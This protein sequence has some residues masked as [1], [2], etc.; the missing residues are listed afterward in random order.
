VQLS[1]SNIGDALDI[2]SNNGLEATSANRS[3]RSYDGGYV[4]SCSQAAWSNK[5]PCVLPRH[6]LVRF[7]SGGE[8]KAE[9]AMTVDFHVD[10][11]SSPLFKASP[12]C[13]L[14]RRYIRVTR[15]SLHGRY[16]RIRAPLCPVHLL[17][18][19]PISPLTLHF[20]S[21]TTSVFSVK[22]THA[23]HSAT[24]SPFASV[25]P[26]TLWQSGDLTPSQAQG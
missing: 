12:V 5:P 16:Y 20:R 9:L 8:P 23:L 17:K 4:R 15:Y 3:S 24:A 18:H 10:R 22:C 13:R 1:K 21:T 14:F 2:I 25:L 11:C 6:P 7:M 19:P 26:L